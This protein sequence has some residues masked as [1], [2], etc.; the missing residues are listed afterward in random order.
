M[1][2]TRN[3][4]KKLILEVMHRESMILTEMVEESDVY[5]NLIRKLEGHDGSI[6]TIGIMSGQNPM[7]KD[8]ISPQEQQQ[9]A[10]KLL[11]DLQA[12]GIDHL[13]IDGNYGNLP[14]KSVVIFN[15]SMEEMEKINKMYEQEA[16]V[17]GKKTQG[18]DDQIVIYEM[19]K[20]DYQGSGSFMAPGSKRATRV[21]K[22]EE[23]ASA[24]TNYSEIDGK[25]FGFELY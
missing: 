21:M 1:K 25:R 19:R 4:L 22:H 2:L 13:A 10:E 6:D 9:R 20:I 24:A 14:E 23:L 5:E 16:F 12:M 8:D 18:I 15:P 11:V 7:A 3:R 17:Y